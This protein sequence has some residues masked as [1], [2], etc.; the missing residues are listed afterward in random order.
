MSKYDSD[1][2]EIDTF[3]LCNG[4]VEGTGYNDDDEKEDSVQFPI[5]HLLMDDDELSTYIDTLI[6]HRKKFHKE[7]LEEYH[8]QQEEDRKLHERIKASFYE[9]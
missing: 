1:Y 8:K 7:A 6:Y 3:S 2:L 9:K 5:E 4:V